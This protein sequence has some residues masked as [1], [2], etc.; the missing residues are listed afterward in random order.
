[1]PS[2]PARSH[3]FSLLVKPAGPDCNLRCDYCF[4]LDHASMFGASRRHRM[5]AP[6]LETMIR[7]YMATSQP[8]Y[9]FGWQGGEPTLMGTDFFQRV[10]ELQQ[11]YGPRGASVSNGLQTNGTLLDDALSEH[12]AKF[13][14]LVGISID[15]PAELHNHFRHAAGNTDAHALVMQGLERLRLHAVE[16][17]VLTLVSQANVSAPETVYHYLRDEL[18][19]RYH[20]YIECVEF[21]AGGTLRPFA[22]SAGQWGD[23]LTR[24]FDLWY[25]D[26]TRKVS[27]RSFDTLLA[28]L[29]DNAEITCA[30]GRDCR[31]YFV[32]EHN[33]DIFP[34]DFHVDPEWRLGNVAGENWET[35]WHSPV[36]ERFG[37]RKREWHQTCSS[38]PY[39][40]FCHGDCPK[41]RTPSTGGPGSRGLSHLCAGW[42]RFY[43]HALPRLEDLA[44]DIR[45]E[46]RAAAMNR[47]ASRETPPG[48][49]SPCPCGSGRKF[50]HCCGA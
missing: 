26:D 29:V 46:R 13:H 41:N 22:V 14:F 33:G 38:C 1:M 34:C 49:N 17:N 4:Y 23:F 10:T 7:S 45:H 36:F 19:V 12:L 44:Q 31:Q 37:Q 15:G 9:A 24:I 42:Q 39:L 3:P 28:K 30:A 43:R 40:R 32:V 20:Q 18:G 27:V 5:S 50:K 35:L 21:D 47:I 8:Q 25:A 11:Q 6:V 16:F 48:R 2:P